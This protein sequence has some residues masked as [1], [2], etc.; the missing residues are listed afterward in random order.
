VAVVYILDNLGLGTSLQAMDNSVLNSD[1]NFFNH[2]MLFGIWQFY[3][4][5]ENLVVQHIFRLYENNSSRNNT[6]LLPGL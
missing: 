5:A 3:T 2:R 4:L 1:G 6:S